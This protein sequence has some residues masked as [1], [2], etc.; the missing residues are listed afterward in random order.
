MNRLLLDLMILVLIG[1]DPISFLPHG[2]TDYSHA[3][4]NKTNVT[5]GLLLSQLFAMNTA[6]QK[7]RHAAVLIS[8]LIKESGN[9]PCRARVGP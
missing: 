9:L 6:A 2:S 8:V 4:L 5:L 1:P 3:N 7:G